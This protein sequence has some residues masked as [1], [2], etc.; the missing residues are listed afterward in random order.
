MMDYEIA[1]LAVTSH[2]FL[3]ACADLYSNKPGWMDRFTAFCDFAA[4]SGW[5][6]QETDARCIV[7]TRLDDKRKRPLF[8][9]VMPGSQRVYADAGFV[10]GGGTH[11]IELVEAGRYGVEGPRDDA[12]FWAEAE[13]QAL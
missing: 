11:S 5:L 2:S 4:K 7:L 8:I 6:A 9:H 13:G 10:V 3:D 12:A 1:K